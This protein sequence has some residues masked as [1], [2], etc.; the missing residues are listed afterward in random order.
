MKIRIDH[1]DITVSDGTTIL[2]A[3]RS[4]G[5]DIPSMCFREGHH[6]H[7]S[8]MICVVKDQKS[9]RMLPACATA[10]ADGMDILSI[11]HEIR[12]ARREALEL[13]MS[14]HVGDCEAPCRTACPAFMNIPQM[15]RLIA[16]GRWHDAIRI[17]KQEIALPLVLG[18]ICPAPCEKVCHRAQIDEPVAICRLKR[19]AAAETT[20][21]QKD[22]LPTGKSD[23]KVAVI[24]AG[25]AGL[26]CGWHL[27]QKGHAVVIF[28]KEP[29]AGGTLLRMDPRELPPE[30]LQTEI[31]TICAAGVEIRLNQEI[32]SDSFQNTLICDFDAIIIAAGA[33]ETLPYNFL[34]LEWHDTGI[35]ANPETYQTH[36]TGVFACG[37]ILR[38]QKM[39]VK[40]VAQ[41]KAA[42]LATDRYLN[43]QPPQNGRRRFNTKIG[44]LKP[45]D[46]AAYLNESVPGNQIVPADRENKGFT[47]EEAR[48]EAARCMHCDCRKPE[49]CKLR[50]YADEYH[51]ER[52]KYADAE[53]PSINKRMTH[54]D[55]VYE[56]GKCIR[57]GLCIDIAGAAK[58]LPGLTYIGRGFD[59]RVDVPF[60]EKIETA[61]RTTALRCA[62]AC[63]TGAISKKENNA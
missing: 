55:I 9:G 61:L 50:F 43:G 62:E 59:V 10:A 5:I 63:P 57:C 20:T 51:I 4:V 14:G 18:Y 12:E 7:P 1:K 34:G 56:P 38:K 21:L 13:L 17:I 40:A 3:A 58:D 29:Q 35:V 23:K 39:A 46:F 15:N 42:A 37:S 48:A 52:N 47:T 16:A 49:D 22:I 44:R 24:G 36:Q 30:I 45:E 28:E 11:D 19:F 8:C 41:G 32:S 25:P 31:N 53:R 54:P 2:Q 60:G 26:A 27:A 6:N 33:L